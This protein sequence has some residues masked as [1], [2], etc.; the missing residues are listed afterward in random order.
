M[1]GLFVAIYDYETSL[2]SGSFQ[3]IQL[4]SGG[5][6]KADS[7]YDTVLNAR[8]DETI[9]K[10][11]RWIGTICSALAILFLALRNHYRMLW[12]N[13]LYK[14][15]IQRDSIDQDTVDF[16]TL[17]HSSSP[18]AKYVLEE[19]KQELENEGDSAKAKKL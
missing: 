5:S 9:N 12:K 14:P 13:N 18:D 2:Y 10:P 11:L 8:M 19:M 7:D 4:M 3:K 6:P 15:Q 17:D 16:F 1:L